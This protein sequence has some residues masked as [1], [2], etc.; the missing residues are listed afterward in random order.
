M[1]FN[2]NIIDAL[3]FHSVFDAQ[4]CQG[5]AIELY[6]AVISTAQGNVVEIGS[7]CGGTTIVLIAAAEEVNKTVY[8]IDPYPK[9]LEGLAL[10]YTEGLMQEFEAK[11]KENILDNGWKNIIQ[12]KKKLKDCIDDL[13]DGLSVVF[14]DSCHE[15]SYVLTDIDL[16][17]PKMM[18]GGRIY[19]HD[20]FWGTGQISG[21]KSDGLYNAVD[22]LYKHKNAELF[23]VEGFPRMLRINT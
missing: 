4:T 21:L 11:F 17:E 19:L 9:E 15:L 6:Q 16:I 7:A 5:E 3:N 14:I 8:S 18:K 12:Y 20:I 1:G 23:L 22:I 2:M 13:P 10:E